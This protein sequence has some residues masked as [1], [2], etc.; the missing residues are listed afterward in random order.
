MIET[1]PDKFLIIFYLQGS[2]RSAIPKLFTITDKI[3]T[4]LQKLSQEG[5]SQIC[6]TKTVNDSR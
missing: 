1:I 4:F 3:C 2:H 6:H 5:Q